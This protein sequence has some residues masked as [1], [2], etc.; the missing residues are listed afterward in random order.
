ME[1]SPNNPNLFRYGCLL[2]A[3]G[4]DFEPEI[5]LSETTFYSKRILYQ[6]KLG[7]RTFKWAGV[8]RPREKVIYEYS[9]LILLVSNSKSNATRIEEATLFLKKYRSE[10]TRL[11]KFKGVEKITLT[12]SPLGFELIEDVPDE[13]NDLANEC[14]IALIA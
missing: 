13:L 14:G 9:N 2:D 3:Y 4:I 11:A 1:E 12:F 8:T 10:I 7:F 5:F 6:G